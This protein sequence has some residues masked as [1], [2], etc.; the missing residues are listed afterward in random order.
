MNVEANVE[1]R[2]KWTPEEFIECDG[3]FR[4]KSRETHLRNVNHR[5]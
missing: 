5:Q 4:R 2:E 1:L 3:T